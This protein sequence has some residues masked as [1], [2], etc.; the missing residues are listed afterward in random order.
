MSLAR[1]VLPAPAP[2]GALTAGVTGA[3]LAVVA[4]GNAVVVPCHRVTAGRAGSAGG[5]ARANLTGP[6]TTG[7]GSTRTPRAR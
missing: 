7:E 5:R 2:I 6:A 3:G 4:F 1:A